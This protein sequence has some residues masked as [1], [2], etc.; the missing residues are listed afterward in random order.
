MAIAKLTESADIL[1]FPVHR[2]A[3][4]RTEPGSQA[5][6]LFFTGVRYERHPAPQARRDGSRPARKR[7]G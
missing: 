5:T 7:R 1:A 6:I 2:V 4:A 3:A